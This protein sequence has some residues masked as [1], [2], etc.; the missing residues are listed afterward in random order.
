[1]IYLLDTDT[2]SQLHAGDPRLRERQ[3]RLGASAV[4]TTVLTRIEILQ[5]RFD[6]VLKAADGEQLLRAFAWLL[7]SEELFRQI[8]VLPIN[9]AVA[10]EFDQLRRNEKLK[11]IGRADLLIAAVALAHGATVVTR[12]LRHFRQIRGLQVENWFD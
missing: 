5:G 12:N 10:D 2:L 4:A 11:K 3:A 8:T 1:V 9:E 6:F 7:R